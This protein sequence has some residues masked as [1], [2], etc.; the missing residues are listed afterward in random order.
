MSYA[1]RTK[2]PP[3]T[4]GDVEQARLLKVTGEHRDGFRDC[5]IFSLA[6]GTALRES[7]LVALDVGDVSPDGKKVRRRVTLRVFKRASDDPA[8]QEVFLPDGT[9][10]KIEKYLRWKARRGESL[11]PDAPLFVSR[12]HRR[13]STRML[14]E[15]FRLW[16]QR[17]GFDRLYTFHSMR[18]SSCTNLYR[19]TKDIRVVQ[20]QA[21]HKNI[22]TTTIYAVPSDEDLLR[23]VRGL[24]S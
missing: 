12:N 4:L 3:R 20:R 16:Q 8:P 19:Q 7:E 6:L 15:A 23:A 17:A 14:R 9:F 18:H 21:R 24:M 5:V 2:K 11:A 13:L 22:Q 1:E 10:Y